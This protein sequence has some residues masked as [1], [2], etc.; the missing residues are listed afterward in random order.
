V[1]EVTT[2]TLIGVPLPP[3]LALLEPLVVGLLEPAAPVLLLELLQAAANVIATADTA[4]AAP[5]LRM[6]TGP[7]R[8]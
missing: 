2:P 6:F 7:P 4:T 1:I 5:V 3:A 8:L